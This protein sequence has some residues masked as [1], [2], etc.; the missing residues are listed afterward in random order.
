MLKA[1]I[2]KVITVLI[3]DPIVFNGFYI[4]GTLDNGRYEAIALIENRTT[5]SLYGVAGVN[6]VLRVNFHP[7]GNQNGQAERIV[8]VHFESLDRI[9]PV[10]RSL[11]S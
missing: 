8:A 2:P 6:Q 11:F 3:S 5:R 10:G 4:V 7:A 9:I 1:V